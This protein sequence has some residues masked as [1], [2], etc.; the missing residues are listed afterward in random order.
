MRRLVIGA[1]DASLREGLGERL[2]LEPDVRVVGLAADLAESLR[3][4][5][6]HQPDVLIID[7]RLGRTEDELIAT[8]GDDRKFGIVLLVPSS[9][10]SDVWRP[11]GGQ[12]RVPRDASLAALLG[13]I[14]MAALG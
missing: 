12:V 9:A 8:F 14:R 11:V 5:H 10:S 1:D 2:R 4:V 13:A 3:L 6:A 7:A